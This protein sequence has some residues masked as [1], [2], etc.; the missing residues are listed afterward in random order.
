[1]TPIQ[2]AY[3]KGIKDAREMAMIAA[4][5]IE[6]RDDH[7]EVRQQAAAAALHGFADGLAQLLPAKNGVGSQ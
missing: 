1:M 3:A 2:A 4:I 7:R 6:S 5:T